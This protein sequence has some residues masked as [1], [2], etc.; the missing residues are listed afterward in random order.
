MVGDRTAAAD[1]I[2]VDIR[3]DGLPIVHQRLTVGMEILRL[4]GAVNGCLAIC[5]HAVNLF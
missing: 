5:H 4:R 3:R 1:E 2:V